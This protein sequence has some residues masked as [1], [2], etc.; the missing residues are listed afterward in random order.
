FLF[1]RSASLKVN[2]LEAHAC[3]SGLASRATARERLHIRALKAW[4]EGDWLN[5]QRVWDAILTDHPLDLLA[6]RVQHFN[7]IFLG[8]PDYLRSTITRALGDWDDAIPGAG[9]VYGMT[10][11]GLEETGD[12]ERAE[13]VGRRGAELEPDDLWSVHSVAHVMEA[14]GR[15]DEGIDW[16][17]RPDAFWDGRGPMRHHLWWHEVL[18]LYEA[19]AYDQVVDYY[20][21]RLFAPEKPTYMEMSN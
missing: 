1:A 8:Q 5:A 4:A 17:V 12:F 11:M 9:F 10:C 3:A 7:A 21:T 19:G 14:Q 13:G 16:M 15:L 6:L 2:A 18:F 20:D